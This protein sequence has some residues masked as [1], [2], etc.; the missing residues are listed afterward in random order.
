MNNS[1]KCSGLIIAG[2]IILFI[3][4]TLCTDKHYL[5][6]SFI[7][8]LFGMSPFFIKFEKEDLKAEEMVIISMLSALA[9]IGR[10]PFAAIPSVQPTSFIIIMSAFV[11]GGEMAF[12]VGSIAALVS[13]MLLGQG[14][15]TPWQMFAW[16]MM[17]F[18]AG[19][20]NNT[21][22]M[23]TT[24]GKVIFGA[25]WGFLFG[26][27]MNLWGVLYMNSSTLTWKVYLASCIASFKFDL[28]HAISNVVFISLFCNRWMKILNRIK[29]KYRLG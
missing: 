27:I 25:I 16:G 6:I 15:W 20:L 23:K 7:I 26:W 11:F 22:F 29:I 8:L 4:S 18:S 19:L 3:I 1:R 14:P 5:T 24:F 21:K 10:V 13:N 28:N 17:G 9:A 12:M 2:F